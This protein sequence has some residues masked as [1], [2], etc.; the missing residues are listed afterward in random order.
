MN[1]FKL[2]GLVVYFDLVSVR[3]KVQIPSMLLFC[4]CLFPMLFFQNIRN[5]KHGIEVDSSHLMCE[6]EEEQ[7]HKIPEQ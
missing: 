2:S 7:A 4:V 1:V 5:L 3:I 6:E